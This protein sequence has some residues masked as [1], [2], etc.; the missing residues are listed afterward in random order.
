MQWC[1]WCDQQRKNFVIHFFYIFFLIVNR[2]SCGTAI[3]TDSDNTA[4]LL[5]APSTG[6]HTANVLFQT[7]FLLEDLDSAAQTGKHQRNDQKA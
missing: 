6:E 4:V 5:N 2:W 1:G 7:F 3:L